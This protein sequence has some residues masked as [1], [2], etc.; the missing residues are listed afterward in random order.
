V[1]ACL[2]PQAACRVPLPSQVANYTDFYTSIHHARN[3]GQ[4]SGPT[5]R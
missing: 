4:S 1:Q 2:V 3:V 5:T